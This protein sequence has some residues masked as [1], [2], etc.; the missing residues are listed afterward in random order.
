MFEKVLMSLSLRGEEDLL[1]LG[2]SESCQPVQWKEGNAYNQRVPHAVTF[3]FCSCLTTTKDQECSGFPEANSS[4]PPC[5]YGASEGPLFTFSRN[6]VGRVN[7]IYLLMLEVRHRQLTELLRRIMERPGRS[8]RDWRLD[9]NMLRTV[10]PHHSNTLTALRV[11]YHMIASKCTHSTVLAY[12]NNK[13]WFLDHTCAFYSTDNT[14]AWPWVTC[15]KSGS[16]RRQTSCVLVV[17]QIVKVM[18]EY[19]S[20][21]VYRI[22]TRACH[23]SGR[24]RAGFDSPP[25]SLIMTQYIFIFALFYFS[26]PTARCGT[27]RIVS[28]MIRKNK[29]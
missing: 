22:S 29:S 15:V 7:I 25:G 4:L 24:A 20:L 8:H 21:V 2:G 5:Q 16:P 13:A 14:N 26:A 23:F 10:Y 11:L 6:M 18:R 1:T 9:I 17:S 27:S 19:Q 12:L 3:P 28:F